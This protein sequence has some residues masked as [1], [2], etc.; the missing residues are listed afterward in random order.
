MAS[1]KLLETLVEQMAAQQRRHEEQMEALLS[2]LKRQTPLDATVRPKTAA[3]PAFC[4]FD[5]TAELWKDYWSRF[6]T[7]VEAHGVEATR[8]THV[9]LTNQSPVVYKTLANMAN[10]QSPAK[11]VNSLSIKEIEAYMSEQFHPKRYVVRERFKFWT[12]M[13]RK[14]GETI[15]ELAARIRQ[16]AVTC[17][18]PSITDPLN[19][20]MRTRFL[21]S[22]KNE[23]VLK[24]VFKVKDDEL[25]F[26]RAIEIATET[27]EAAKVAKETVHGQNTRTVSKVKPK[28]P[29]PSAKTCF[30]CDKS[31][32]AAED[33]RY[34]QTICNYCK[35]KGHLE[36]AC[37]KKKKA[38]ATAGK[39]PAGDKTSVKK[40]HAITGTQGEDIP[41]LRLPLKLNGNHTVNFEV[42]TGAGAWSRNVDIPGQ[43]EAQRARAEIRDSWE[44][45]PT[46]TGICSVGCTSGCTT[47]PAT[48]QDRA[49]STGGRCT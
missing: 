17:D 33:C 28:Q 38:I 46:R 5:P 22:I 4:P 2:L 24:A 25:T 8:I 41:E 40:I 37:R 21:C 6:T 19:E 11:E 13:D 7:Y 44:S 39:K 26:A 30:R 27:E 1:E 47:Q 3:L 43:T 10:Q 18:F 14:P 49:G 35:I 32:H 45:Q 34:Q 15:Q 12:T 36:T 31:G 23:A 16:D 20:A 42:D 48:T 9:F 29:K